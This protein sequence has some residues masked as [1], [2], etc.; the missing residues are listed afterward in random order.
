MTVGFY[1]TDFYGL[2]RAHIYR[3]SPPPPHTHT[4]NNRGLNLAA[5]KITAVRVTELALQQPLG[6]LRQCLFYKADT[7]TRCIWVKMFKRF[8][9]THTEGNCKYTELT[10]TWL[11]LTDRTALRSERF[12]QGRTKLTSTATL[13]SG[14]KHQ[15]NF[16]SYP[17]IWP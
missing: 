5:M 13:P 6:T 14:H 17:P 10:N 16:H 9:N 1:D 7:H 11:V 12:P 8:V 15:A 2:Y 3:A 4:Q